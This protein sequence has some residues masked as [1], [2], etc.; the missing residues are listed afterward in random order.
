MGKEIHVASNETITLK[1]MENWKVDIWPP[2]SPQHIY[3]AYYLAKK[4]TKF[5]KKH[6]PP[7]QPSEQVR[8]EHQAYVIGC[9]FAAVAFLESMINDIFIEA[10]REVSGDPANNILKSLPQD[11]I[12][13]MAR[14]WRFGIRLDE[15]NGIE[16]NRHGRETNK[17]HK[18]LVGCLDK[19]E[20]ST[21]VDW[22]NTLNKYQLTYYLTNEKK[23]PN[24]ACLDKRSSAWQDVNLLAILRN[25][26]THYKSESIAYRGPTK[27]EVLTPSNIGEL[28]RRTRKLLAGLKDR[29]CGNP[30]FQG[31][32]GHPLEHL[33][34]AN[35][36]NW[37][38][39]ISLDFADEFSKKTGIDLYL[40]IRELIL[41][42]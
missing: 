34:G 14:I 26:L 41:N 11:T 24:G 4:A 31:R 30:L 12:A 33:L 2:F 22:W 13:S 9:V 40:P 10:E 29:K 1:I 27:K 20:S 19:R 39:R 8:Y 21:D 32:G 25:H 42:R 38:F 18:N 16:L 6:L 7:P 5:E 36:A 15:S 35:C 28:R 23:S 37:A 3:S 17:I